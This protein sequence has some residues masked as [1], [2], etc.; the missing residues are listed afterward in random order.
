MG[1]SIDRRISL[2]GLW[3]L[4]NLSIY[5]FI[6][7]VQYC[8]RLFDFLLVKSGFFTLGLK[9]LISM[10]IINLFSRSFLKRIVENGVYSQQLTWMSQALQ[11]MRLFSGKNEQ[12]L[13]SL[14]GKARPHVAQKKLEKDKEPWLEYYSP[15]PAYP[16][17]LAPS[18][19]HLIPSMKD[20][21]QKKSLMEAESIKTDVVCL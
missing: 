18:Y 6:Q 7:S 17:D 13:I 21:F 9:I 8:R 11:K 15:R 5:L 20:F 16:P 1:S 19:Y 10:T 2:D 3:L 12:K 4:I 14:H